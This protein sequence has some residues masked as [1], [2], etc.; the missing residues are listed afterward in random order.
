MEN[1]GLIVSK[2][3]LKG[4]RTRPKLERYVLLT[5]SKISVKELSAPKKKIIDAL[6]QEGELSV[7]KIK[8]AGTIRSRIN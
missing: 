6:K 1:L 4:G 5:S 2:R 3:E 8:G 7:K